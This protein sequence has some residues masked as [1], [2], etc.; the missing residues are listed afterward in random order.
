MGNQI[1]I[2]LLYL[3]AANFGYRSITSAGKTKN[4]E[5]RQKS[6]MIGNSECECPSPFDSAETQVKI[7]Y[8]N[9]KYLKFY[10]WDY[11]SNDSS[12][13]EFRFYNQSDSIILEGYIPTEYRILSLTAPVQIWQSTIMDM[14]NSE[15]WKMTPIFES[16]IV[17]LEGEF[18]VKDV[19]IFD[20]PKMSEAKMDSVLRTFNRQPE[21]HNEYDS[22]DP[23]FTTE[24][25][26]M[27]LFVCA[28]NGNKQ[29]IEA[30]DSLQ[31]RFVVDGAVGELY[32][33]LNGLLQ[34]YK[35][36]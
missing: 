30:H 16:K 21:H 25:Y 13:S 10:S 9:G 6:Q 22:F 12:T 14:G 19:F 18:S 20:P 8:R 34:V 5:A 27:D 29:C 7:D 3:L 23:P 33:E 36:N 32:Y 15:T 4:V 26:V 2:L 17:L 1:S 11:M 28:V 31:Q 35:Q 24:Q